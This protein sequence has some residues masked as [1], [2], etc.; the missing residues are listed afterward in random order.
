MKAS[1]LMRRKVLYS[2]LIEFGVPMKKIKQ[3]NVC[4]NGTYNKVY[5]GKGL[6]IIFS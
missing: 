1:D 4:L 2:I 5:V 6:L 3:I